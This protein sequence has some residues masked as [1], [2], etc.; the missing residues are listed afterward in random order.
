M[1]CYLNRLSMI[2]ARPITGIHN[3][4]YGPVLDM[5]F[6][7]MI[8]MMM[9]SS[10][11]MALSTELRDALISP[12]CR[13]VIVIAHGT[14]ATILSHTMDKMHADLPMELMAR[15]EIYTFG[16]AAKHMSNPRM[17]YE[18]PTEKYTRAD[19]SMTNPAKV[20]PAMQRM[21]MEETERVI[22]VSI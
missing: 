2:F 15:M 17:V 5:M 6:N 21:R 18:R 3:R 10:S 7:A 22:P 1:Q 16:S 19:G 9:N 20:S 12:S 8:P 13:K 4:T 11:S 14:G